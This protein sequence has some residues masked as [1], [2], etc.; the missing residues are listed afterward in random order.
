MGLLLK[1]MGERE[2]ATMVIT[3]LPPSGYSGKYRLFGA[4]AGAYHVMMTTALHFLKRKARSVTDNPKLEVDDSFPY[5]ALC[6]THRKLRLMLTLD[7]TLNV[8]TASDQL[9]YPVQV[10]SQT[11]RVLSMLA[12]SAMSMVSTTCLHIYPNTQL[13]RSQTR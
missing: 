13:R 7:N 9:H 3:T 12:V 1:K 2:G 4:L 8:S 10:T 11:I 5:Q 6:T